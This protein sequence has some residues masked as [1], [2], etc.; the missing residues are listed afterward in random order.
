MVKKKTKDNAPSEAAG[1][2]EAEKAEGEAEPKA[3]PVGLTFEER[4]QPFL[5]RVGETVLELQKRQNG[6]L[7]F[8]LNGAHI[9]MVEAASVSETVGVRGYV[10]TAAFAVVAAMMVTNIFND[11][12]P[13]PAKATESEEPTPK[14]PDEAS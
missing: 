11:K 2:P 3:V 13:P 14:T 6:A 8:G 1:G 5:Q 10:S 4:L 7:R 9:M 12:P